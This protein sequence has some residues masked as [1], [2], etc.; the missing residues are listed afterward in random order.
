M[1]AEM[2]GLVLAAVAVLTAI[3]AQAEPFRIAVISDLNGSY[4][5]IDYAS[6]V[7]AAVARI[8][9]LRPDLVI[10][11][12]DM[13]AGQRRDPPFR[14]PELEA[15]WAAFHAHV[16]DPLRAAGLPLLVTPGNHDA[17]AFPGFDAERDAF[18]LTWTKRSPAV[19]IIDG[20][21]YPFRYAVSQGGVLLIGL[22]VTVPGPLPPE[23]NDWLRGMLREEAKRHRAV[24][25]FGHLPVWPVSVGRES[26]VIGDPAF[27]ALLG[28][29]GADAYLS[30][31]HHA[32]YPAEAGG[33][34]L[35]SMP[36]LGSGGRRIIG[37]AEAAPKA[38][39]LIEIGEDGG[40][41]AS[42]LAPP[43]FAQPVD[44]ATLPP[45][46]GAGAARLVRRDR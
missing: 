35:L 29:G 11:A 7:D 33:V 15:M 43:D 2:R 13:V 42:A 36:R 16:T 18:L 20:E 44:P 19:E 3:A 21:R 34:V 6:E 31:H 28:E 24:I 46:I 10:S 5:S 4:G 1:A 17:S 27:L 9:A 40:V 39:V 32:W 30:G 12:G 23:E 38:L 41:A 25:V 45:A 37:T 22:D 14:A 26:D 8:I